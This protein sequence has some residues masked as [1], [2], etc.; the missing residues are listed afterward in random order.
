M[1]IAAKTPMGVIPI[2]NLYPTGSCFD[3]TLKFLKPLMK[4]DNRLVFSSKYLI[5]HGIL[6][7][8]NDPYAHA[9]VEED[10]LWV[11]FSGLIQPEDK[12]DMVFARVSKPEYYKALK[13]LDVTRYTIMEAYKEEIKRKH[14][15]PWESKYINLCRE[16]KRSKK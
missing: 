7:G 13:V 10:G 12:E 1:I 11:W 3:D 6:G 9:W 5:C 14:P 2:E 8:N 16:F 4:E 15:A